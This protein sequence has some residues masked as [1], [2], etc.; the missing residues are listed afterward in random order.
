MARGLIPT[1]NQLRCAP[2]DIV[3]IERGS[4]QFQDKISLVR[5]VCS[6]LLWYADY[7]CEETDNEI[8]PDEIRLALSLSRTYNPIPVPKYDIG[9][10]LEYQHAWGKQPVMFDRVGRIEIM[11]SEDSNVRY[12]PEGN[13][14][15]IDETD[16]KAVYVKKENT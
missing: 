4:E 7:W 11:W 8:K 1:A 9:D 12:I 2:G 5:I 14:D 16:V 13:I 15:W 3:F 6:E 10:V